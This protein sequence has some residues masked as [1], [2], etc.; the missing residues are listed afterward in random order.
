MLRM[1]GSLCFFLLNFFCKPKP[2]SAP[3]FLWLSQVRDEKS[4]HF[5]LVSFLKATFQRSCEQRPLIQN[6]PVFVIP[7]SCCGGTTAAAVPPLIVGSHVGWWPGI[8]PLWLWILILILFL[9]L[10]CLCLSALIFWLF[11]QNSYNQNRVY[12]ETNAVKSTL[13]PV[14]MTPVSVPALAT[15]PAFTQT[16]PENRETAQQTY[17][18]DFYGKAAVTDP[19]RYAVDSNIGGRHRTFDQHES[20][21]LR[22]NLP[23]GTNSSD[24]AK[25]TGFFDRLR[26]PNPNPQTQYTNDRWEEREEFNESIVDIN[27][28]YGKA[29]L[30]EYFQGFYKKRDTFRIFR[31]ILLAY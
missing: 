21:S 5:F 7:L 8:V 20:I 29:F 26:H 13:P 18:A 24:Q 15:I 2:S 1:C 6:Y 11:R 16:R 17:A 28:P 23:A 12:C 10:L 9:L 19:A 30:K 3:S 14:V 27:S 22:D 25:T 31:D 4:G